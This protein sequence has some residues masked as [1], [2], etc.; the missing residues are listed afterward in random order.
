MAPDR[1]MSCKD[2]P[3]L[4][5]GNDE[6]PKGPNANKQAIRQGRARPSMAIDRQAIDKDH[7]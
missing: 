7:P 6:A 4:S 5:I 2:H 3:C 1:Q